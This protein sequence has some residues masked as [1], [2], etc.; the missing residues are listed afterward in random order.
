MKHV[1]TF[2]GAFIVGLIIMGAWGPVS[3]EYGTIGG[4]LAALFIVFPTWFMDHY[5]GLF[6]QDGAW[7][8]QGL[9]LGAAGMFKGLFLDGSGAFA[10]ALPLLLIVIAGGAAG[11]IMADIADKTMQKENK[12]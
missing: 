6:H 11:G 12:G 7:L 4:W 10:E 5:C 3:A 9:A 8:D 1:R 2:I